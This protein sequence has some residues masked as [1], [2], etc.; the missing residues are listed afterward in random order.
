MLDH[1]GG[2]VALLLLGVAVAAWG[3]SRLAPRSQVTASAA[4]L[5]LAVFASAYLYRVQWPM[6]LPVSE[7]LERT[8][9][10]AMSWRPLP[11]RAVLVLVAIGMVG[12]TVAR[13][14]AILVVGGLGLTGFSLHLLLYAAELR[15]R[16]G[17]EVWAELAAAQELSSSLLAARSGRAYRGRFLP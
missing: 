12:G 10:R 5:G 2:A 4:G 14:D 13:V 9:T 8:R 16:G 11:S 7:R 1:V 3:W 15:R 6:D 17:P